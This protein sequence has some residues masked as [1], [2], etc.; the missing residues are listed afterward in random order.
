MHSAASGCRWGDGVFEL[1]EGKRE[2]KRWSG[3][4]IE[5][6][7]TVPVKEGDTSQSSHVL[8]H[9]TLSELWT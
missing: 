5:G 3:E 8:L 1:G 4:N 6:E 9:T 2:E 7:Y